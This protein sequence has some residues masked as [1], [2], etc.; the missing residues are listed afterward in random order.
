MS[1]MISP[2]AFVSPEAQLGVDVEIGPN[3]YIGPK[4]TLGDRVKLFCGVV[5]DGR[6]SLGAETV[7]YDHAVLGRPPQDFKYQD[8]DTT[9]D[10]GARNVIRENVTMHLG[11]GVGRG[12]TSV[13][14]DGYFMAGAHVGHD[15]VVG[16]R[17]T[18]ANMATLGGHVQVGD[19]VIM[20]GL[21]AVHQHC[22]IGRHA[23][24]GGG[25]IV[26]GDVIPYG[27]VDN[28]GWLAGLNLV[29]L[30]RRGF[31]RDTIQDMRTAYRLFFADEGAFQER[32]D[33]VSRLFE[34]SSEV[35]E[36]VAFIRD[37][38]HRPLCTP[39]SR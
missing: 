4:V 16:D 7:V 29:G 34:A 22:R 2:A 10:I 32:V 37:Q 19:Q 25:A 5:I 33:D 27:M 1:S 11:T 36:M 18:F 14:N 23:F 30:K 24:L 31:S 38:G 6:T 3:C 39:E 17:V 20:G 9:L 13:G 28:R 12:A 35:G 26:T 8:E 21:S 15:C